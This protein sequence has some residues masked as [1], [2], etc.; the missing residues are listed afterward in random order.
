[1]VR[2]M[3]AIAA[4]ERTRTGTV[5]ILPPSAWHK[6][7]DW[8]HAQGTSPFHTPEWLTIQA[9]A[10]HGRPMCVSVLEAGEFKDV[11]P[12]VVRKLGPFHVGSSP[13]HVGTPYGGTQRRPID[14]DIGRG[15]AGLARQ[16]RISFLDVYLDPRVAVIS[17]KPFRVENHSTYVLELD[18]DEERVLQ[19]TESRCR[20][21]IR[22]A[23]RLGVSVR[24]M[25]LDDLPVYEKMARDTYAHQG[26]SPPLPIEVV[27]A[28]LKD[29][30]LRNHTLALVAEAGGRPLAAGIFPWGADTIYYVDGVSFRSGLRL[31]PNNLL[32]WTVIQRALRMGLTRYD[33][34]GASVGS[35]GLFK[36]SFGAA[37]VPHSRIHWG[38]SA[39]R[40]AYRAWN[41][42]A[43]PSQRSG[44]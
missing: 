37:I 25:S 31:A 7:R 22:K 3:D 16:E 15:L 33:L 27:S 19:R 43:R 34:V 12:V 14:G 38:T 32:H 2:R 11:I 17:P 44:G 9:R 6:W 29:P 10:F 30:V 21:A 36:R 13:I 35:I 40:V 20:R 23:V 18:Q 5:E 28:S 39:A 1:M 42:T 4:D 24:E 26:R 41:W 8:A